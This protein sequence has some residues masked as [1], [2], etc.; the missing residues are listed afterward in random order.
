LDHQNNIGKLKYSVGANISFIKNELTSLNGGDAI[1]GDRVKS[2][3][4]LPL[5]SYWGY[6]YDG[7]YKTDEEAR[8]YLFGYTSEEIQYH[9]GDAKFA[10]L[11]GNGRID[12][13]D[14]TNSQ[15]DIAKTEEFKRKKAQGNINNENDQRGE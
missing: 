2:D 9:A 12:D 8:E 4:G 7:I 10:D 13:K 11:D 14:K 15:W 3:L 6:K 5:F 1:Y